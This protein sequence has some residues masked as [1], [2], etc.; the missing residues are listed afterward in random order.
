MKDAESSFVVWQRPQFRVATH[1]T[2][3]L[4]FR[5][6]PLIIS[7]LWVGSR[8]CLLAICSY[9]DLRHGFNPANSP[10]YQAFHCTI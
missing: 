7:P 8:S 1:A 10:G 3:D 2:G 6:R 9:G 4:H 5:R